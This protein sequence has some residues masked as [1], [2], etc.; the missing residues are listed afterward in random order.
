PPEQKDYCRSVESDTRREVG[1]PS[2]TGQNCSVDSR[3]PESVRVLRGKTED[4]FVP[5]NRRPRKRPRTFSHCLRG[6]GH[7][8]LL[9]RRRQHDQWFGHLHTGIGVSYVEAEI[10]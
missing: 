9:C 6:S 5:P 2:K 4:G 3:S 7:S 1:S 8:R 10:I